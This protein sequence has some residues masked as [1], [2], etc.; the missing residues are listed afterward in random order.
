MLL[1]RPLFIGP[2]CRLERKICRE[3]VKALSIGD[4]GFERKQVVRLAVERKGRRPVLFKLRLRGGE[5]L[6]H[7]VQAGE[8][9]AGR[10]AGPSEIYNLFLS[11]FLNRPQCHGRMSESRWTESPTVSAPSWRISA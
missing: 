3:D 1:F 4:A 8:K 2:V 9:A 10:N 6:V 11:E 7:L 5:H